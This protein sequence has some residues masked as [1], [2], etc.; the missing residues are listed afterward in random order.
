V[1]WLYDPQTGVMISYDDAESLRYKAEY[2][3][4]SSLGGAMV[5]DLSGDDAEDTLLQTLHDTLAQ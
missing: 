1:P 3:N 5:W 2:V 4:E